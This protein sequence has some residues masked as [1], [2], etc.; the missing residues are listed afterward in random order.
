MLL[1]ESGKLSGSPRRVAQGQGSIQHLTGSVDG[2]VI[3]F[4]SEHWSPSVYIDTLAPD[5]AHL[6]ANRRLTLDENVNGPT[7]WTPDSKA[8]LFD[9]DRNGTFGI[10]KQT[11]DQ[12]LAENLMT[13]AED[14][15]L[16]D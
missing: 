3:T 1:Q 14:L 4:L 5:G 10:F 16:L 9:S 15:Y 13:S 12:P 7:S 8:V 11:T 2:K 6:L